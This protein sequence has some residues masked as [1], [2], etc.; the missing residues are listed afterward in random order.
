MIG[1]FYPWVWIAWGALFFV[2]ELVPLVLRQDRYT[3]SEYIWR[4]EDYAGYWTFVRYL[5]AA[6]TLWLFL[7]LTFGILR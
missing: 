3:L 2:F 4:L 6:A 1:R 5:V 7:H